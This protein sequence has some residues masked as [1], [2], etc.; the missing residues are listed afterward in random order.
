[1]ETDNLI[2]IFLFHMFMFITRDSCKYHCYYWGS[3]SIV[4]YFV[5]IL[6]IPHYTILGY[7][8]PMQLFLL[9]LVTLK[10]DELQNHIYFCCLTEYL[11]MQNDILLRRYSVLILDEAHERSLN[12]DI[13]IGILSRVIRIRHEVYQSVLFYQYFTNE[14]KFN[15]VISYFIISLHILLMPSTF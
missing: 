4:Y 2:T 1:M 15:F 12:T 11:L 8:G 3:V 5:M 13:L 6:M 7:D 10:Q 14:M 9:I